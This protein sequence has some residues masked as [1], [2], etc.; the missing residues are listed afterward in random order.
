MKSY[1]LLEELHFH[2]YHGVGPQERLVGND[3]VVNLR[4]RTDISKAMQSDEVKDTVSYADVFSAVA[5]EM[6]QPSNLLEHVAG[7]IVNRL[8]ERFPSVEEISLR[9][10]KRNPPMNADIRAAGVELSMERF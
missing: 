10:M 1:I 7:R 8:F 4:L 6:E 3:F 5:A 9:L 2:A